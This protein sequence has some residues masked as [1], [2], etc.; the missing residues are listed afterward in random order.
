M[1]KLAIP[2]EGRLFGGIFQM[3][4]Y[5]RARNVARTLLTNWILLGLILRV[6]GLLADH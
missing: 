5:N 2:I 3:I 6:A 4:Q 1:L